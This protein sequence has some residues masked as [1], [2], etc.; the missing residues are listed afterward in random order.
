MTIDI[1]S[2]TGSKKGTKTLPDSLFGTEVNEGLMHQ[3]LV[4]QQNNR[5]SAI[6]HAQNRGVVRGSTAKL[7]RQKGT[8]RA[9]R[10]SK[11]SPI[12]RGGGKA[13]G[14]KNVRNYTKD[15]P[16]AMRRA[17][18]RSC[19]TLA[20]QDQKIIGLENYPEEIKTKTFVALLQKLPVSVGR[21]IVFVVPESHP[22]LAWSSRNV[23]GVKTI[24]A[25]YLNPE[26]LLGAYHIVFVGD[27]IE[28]AEAVFGSGPSA[29]SGGS[30]STKAKAKVSSS[31]DSTKKSNS[32]DSVSEPG[33]GPDST[34]SGE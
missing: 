5:R 3:A 22:E 1:Y 7:Y 24:L 34:S 28:K 29:G 30:G 18:I 4:R 17:A 11:K 14:P 19:L 6:A 31:K 20:A 16:R 27:A 26:D 32:K 2:S 8:G 12:L 10:G 13:F 9:R 15:M 23:P 33:P 21:K 25:S